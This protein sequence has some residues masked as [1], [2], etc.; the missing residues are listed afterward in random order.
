MNS[1]KFIKLIKNYIMTEFEIFQLANQI[2]I[3]NAVVFI[4]YSNFGSPL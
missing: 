1:S 3:N 2:Y 4:Q